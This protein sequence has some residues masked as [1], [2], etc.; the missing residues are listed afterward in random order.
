[1]LRRTNVDRMTPSWIRFVLTIALVGSLAG[2]APVAWAQA[3]N[4]ALSGRIFQAD[5]ATPYANVTVRVMDQ[6]TGEAV[7]S[8]NTGTDGSYSFDTLDP[9]T[10]TFEVEVPDGIYQLDRAVQIG[11]DEQASISFT[12]KPAA[13]GGAVPP[14]GAGADGGSGMGKKKKGW[15]IGAIAFGAV[16]VGVLLSQDDN[17]NNE[18][19]PFTP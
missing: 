3:E 7:A 14:P 13:G 19:S 1:M 11:M 9:G 16:A 17:S 10:Y 6:E 12:I 8:T 15:L 5:G 18:A 2:F 4:V